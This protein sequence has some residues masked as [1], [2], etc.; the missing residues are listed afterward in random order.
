MSR[1]PARPAACLAALALALLPAAARGQYVWTGAGPDGNWGTAAN[2]TGGVPA[3]GVNTSLTFAVTTNL[4]TVD[5]LAAGFQLN[6][7]V[8]GSTAGAFN[9][10]GNSLNF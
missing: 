9:L 2:W 8:F 5:N 6:G 4:T 3:P 10:S 1:P 7:L